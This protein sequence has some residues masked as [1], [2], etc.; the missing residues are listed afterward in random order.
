MN[1]LDFDIWSFLLIIGVGQGIFL[2]VALFFKKPKS[3]SLKILLSLLIILTA[4]L[5]EFL[6]LS[7]KY[8][9]FVPHLIRTTHPLLF[10][11]GPLFYF[12][13]KSHLEP[14]F[15]FNNI[16]LIHLVPFFIGFAYLAPWFFE[17]SDYKLNAFNEL[18]K[19]E[20]KGVSLK[21]ILY[22]LTHIS[23]TL[24]YTVNGFKLIRKFIN[25]NQSSSLLPN[26]RLRFLLLFNKFFLAYWVTQLIGL[27][28]ITIAQ[29]YVLY[30]DYALALINSFFI[31]ILSVQFLL[32]PDFLEKS[33][34]NKKYDG[35]SLSKG[36]H[37][38]LLE[39]INNLIVNK[40][41]YLDSQLT[42]QK[43]SDVLGINKNY[44]SQVINQEFDCGFNDY[45]N[46]FRIKKAQNL[47]RNPDYDWMKLLAIALESGFNN[48]TSFNRVFKKKV[49][50][51]PSD[52]RKSAHALRRKQDTID[53]LYLDNSNS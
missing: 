31:Q 30:I 20:I 40:E 18:L 48:K 21:G 17:S 52:Y 49:G 36:A 53:K 7:S 13:I 37:Q 28:A 42:L 33:K 11:I 35:S 24:A 19:G 39:K 32:R 46:S 27:M 50:K 3:A 38:S 45:I 51:N 29:Y 9:V 25:S 14:K 47:L 34:W 15:R 5:A 12:F 2:C 16:Q 4:N 22:P 26:N 6:L 8:Y 44:I 10:L 1:L 43:F 41:K 23:I